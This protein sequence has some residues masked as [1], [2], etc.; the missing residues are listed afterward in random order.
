MAYDTLMDGEWIEMYTYRKGEWQIE[1][2][3][4]GTWRD[5]FFLNPDFERLRGKGCLKS[6]P[7]G[8][9]LHPTPN[10]RLRLFA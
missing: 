7:K 10:E 2:A 3:P 9:T 5:L 1:I 4:D 8:D 6:S